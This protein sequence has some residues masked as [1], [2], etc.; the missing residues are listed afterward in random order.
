MRSTGLSDRVCINAQTGP[1]ATGILRGSAVVDSL[2]RSMIVSA[3]AAMPHAEGCPRCKAPDGIQRLL[4]SMARYYLC[5]R[6]DCRW[7]V[8]RDP[9]I[10]HHRDEPWSNGT[11]ADAASSARVDCR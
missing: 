1:D 4:T 3:V 7:Q 11:A 2:H 8:S 6:C 10:K 9:F 5:G